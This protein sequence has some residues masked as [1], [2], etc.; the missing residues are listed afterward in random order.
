MTAQ[1]VFRL[2]GFIPLLILAIALGCG[3]T[4]PD[5]SET[6]GE[7]NEIRVYEVFGMDCPGCHGGLE[8]LVNEIPDVVT[9]KANWEKQRLQ[10]VLIPDSSIDDSIILSAIEKANF[11]AGKRL[12]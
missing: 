5:I 2:T 12:Q 8:K 1:N 6:A 4:R 11:T 9:S 3:S 10:V 7:N